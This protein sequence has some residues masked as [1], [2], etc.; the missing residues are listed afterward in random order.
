[1]SIYLRVSLVLRLLLWESVGWRTDIAN[2]SHPLF[3]NMGIA[4]ALTHILSF[5]I[6]F[7]LVTFVHVVV[8]ELAP[9]TFAIQKAE[10]V[11]LL[12]ARPLILFYKIM[13]PSF[14]Y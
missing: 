6:A 7:A 4:A 10:T 8:G 2:H 12:F 3:E 5:I 11:T 13:F 9:K 1:M 14:G